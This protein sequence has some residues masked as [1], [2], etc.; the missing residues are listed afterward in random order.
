MFPDEVIQSALVDK[1]VAL[2]DKESLDRDMRVTLT[3]V[4]FNF[5]FQA[6]GY[7]VAMDLAKQ[8]D[9]AYDEEFGKNHGLTD[10]VDC[11]YGKD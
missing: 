6:Y 3:R 4:V 2:Q 9:S 5:I 8:I 7:D 1:I 10:Y 11:N